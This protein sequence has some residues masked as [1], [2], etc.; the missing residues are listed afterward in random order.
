M[1][2]R[3]FETAWE[4][5]FRWCHEREPLKCLQTCK[6]AFGELITDVQRS[7]INLL[8]AKAYMAVVRS[9]KAKAIQRS[10]QAGLARYSQPIWRGSGAFGVVFDSSELDAALSMVQE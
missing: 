4:A 7:V 5:L 9:A 3:P 1:L 10:P 2:I 6:A 8:M